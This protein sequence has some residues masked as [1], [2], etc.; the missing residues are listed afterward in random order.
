M[1]SKNSMSMLITVFIFLIVGVTLAMVL[2]DQISLTRDLHSVT[3]ET[4][5]IEAARCDGEWAFTET[6]N[7]TLANTPSNISVVR[8]DNNTV[9][10]ENTDY[11]ISSWANG[12]ITGLNFLNTS[13]V[14]NST[15]LPNATGVDYKYRPVQY[16]SDSTSRTLLGL[17]IIFFMI[18]VVLYVIHGLG[19]FDIGKIFR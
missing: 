3:N 15:L 8:S 17:I 18:G 10:V 13:T 14:L 16:V 2:A 12:T 6:M 9:L 5:D 1:D 7:L 4:L 11:T 19:I